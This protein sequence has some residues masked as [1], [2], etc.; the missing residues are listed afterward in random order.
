MPGSLDGGRSARRLEHTELRLQLGGM[1][2]KGI[3]GVA[4]ALRV[5]TVPARGEIL[6]SRQARQR[7]GCCP[8]WAFG[9]H[10]VVPPYLRVGALGAFWKYDFSIGGQGPALDSG[11]TTT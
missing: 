7:R 10:L 11:G 5:E 1:S 2:A 4:N 6:V 3:E 8:V 9:C